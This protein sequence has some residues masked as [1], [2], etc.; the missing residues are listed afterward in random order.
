M[1]GAG[2]VFTGEND[3]D[4]SAA[5]SSESTTEGS[6][7]AETSS[8]SSVTSSSGSA[9]QGWSVENLQQ[10]S[11]LPKIRRHVMAKTKD[12]EWK[13]FH[14]SKAGNSGGRHGNL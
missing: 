6:E 5:G 3:A 11:T 8:S 1:G 2:F 4:I 7:Q 14:I 10:G 9:P 12:D 13:E